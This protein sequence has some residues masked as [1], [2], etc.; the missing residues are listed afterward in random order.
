MQEGLRLKEEAIVELAKCFEFLPFNDD[1]RC[2][3]AGYYGGFQL[4]D[5]EIC[6]KLRSAGKEAIKQMGRKILSGSFN[7]TKVSFPIKCMLHSSILE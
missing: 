5:N 6:K 7:L 1:H 2:E 4:L 3:K